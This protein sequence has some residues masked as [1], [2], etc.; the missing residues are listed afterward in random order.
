METFDV[1]GLLPV[2]ND[3]IKKKVVDFDFKIERALKNAISVNDNIYKNNA[4]RQISDLIDLIVKMVDNPT[5][6]KT[7]KIPN[8]IG[9]EELEKFYANMVKDK[10][11]WLL[12]Q[13]KWNQY[14]TKET[15]TIVK[16]NNEIAKYMNEKINSLENK[17]ISF[18]DKLDKVAD[19]ILANSITKP[20]NNE[21][22]ELN[23][24]LSLICKLIQDSG[25]ITIQELAIKTSSSVRTIQRDIQILIQEGVLQHEGS[26]KQGCW[27]V[28]KED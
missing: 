27:V 2:L 20:T 5:A 18:E 4:L 17:L 6:L 12:L 28:L 3:L 11:T 15:N 24:R 16:E 8:F 10:D 19:C 7:M 14:L 25:L 13:M 26:E 22:K 23:E 21:K 1:I 9:R